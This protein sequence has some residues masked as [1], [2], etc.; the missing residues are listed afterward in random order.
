MQFGTL[1]NWPTP[2]TV[3]SV[4]AFLVYRHKGIVSDHWYGEKPMIISNSSLRG[5]V[6]EETWDQFRG[7]HQISVEG[8]PS[9]VPAYEVLR[10]ARGYLGTP[11]DLFRWN[12]DDLIVQIHRLNP[13][14]TQLAIS[15]AVVAIGAM[16]MAARQ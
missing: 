6:T 10:H 2:G 16:V 15:I 1:N 14:H 9:T 12:C 3:V 7:N 13:K 8:Y 5:G 4:P 11:Y